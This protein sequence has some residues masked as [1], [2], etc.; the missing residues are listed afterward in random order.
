[1][2]DTADRSSCPTQVRANIRLCRFD[3]RTSMLI[4]CP[5]FH[6]GVPACAA[7]KATARSAGRVA[8]QPE[9]LMPSFHVHVGTPLPFGAQ[10]RNGGAP[11][12]Q[13]SRHA[14]AQELLLYGA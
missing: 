1:M 8:V 10:S 3:I 13:I 11:I 9:S 12:A 4:P 5:T 14:T 2:G 6:G 7:K